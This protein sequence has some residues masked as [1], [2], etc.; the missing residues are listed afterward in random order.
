MKII[1]VL[2]GPCGFFKI[3]MNSNYKWKKKSSNHNDWLLWVACQINKLEI[4]TK[5]CL[6]DFIK[7]IINDRN[8]F[9]ST[10]IACFIA[11]TIAT[12]LH[13]AG[14]AETSEWP[15]FWKYA[16]CVLIS[17][18]SELTL[19]DTASPVFSVSYRNY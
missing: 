13:H 15:L 4:I 11:W 1:N 7:I 18:N 14:F 9:V 6:L 17:I 19:Y 5:K 16:T 8:I 3:L 2:W 10:S 12:P